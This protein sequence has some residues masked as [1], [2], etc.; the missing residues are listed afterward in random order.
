MPYLFDAAKECEGLQLPAVLKCLIPDFFYRG[1][2]RQAGDGSSGSSGIP[3]KRNAVRNAVCAGSRACIAQRVL[4]FGIYHAVFAAV[5]GIRR[6][7]VD[8]V[9]II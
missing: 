8:R 5:G 9:F 2:E 3:D 7:H 4:I 1:G 6:R